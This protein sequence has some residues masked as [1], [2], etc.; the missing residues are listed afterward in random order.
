MISADQIILYDN[1][2]TRCAFYPELCC[3]RGQVYQINEDVMTAMLPLNADLQTYAFALGSAQTLSN[4]NYHFDSGIQ[5]G[6]PANYSLAQEVLP[7]GSLIYEMYTEMPAY[8]SFRLVN[9]YLS[10]DFVPPPE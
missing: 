9:L 6:N 3:S 1:G 2:N 8:R 7:D 10:D 5:T 4:G